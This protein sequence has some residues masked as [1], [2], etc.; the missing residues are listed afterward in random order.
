M[1]I[2]IEEENKNRITFKIENESDT[3]CNIIVKY[4]ST[5]KNVDFV[6]Y[7]RKHFTENCTYLTIEVNSTKEKRQ[8][9]IIKDMIVS[10]VDDIINNLEKNIII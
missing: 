5:K 8:L 4:L 3:L 2:E 10:G 9:P 7:K 1:K 6:A